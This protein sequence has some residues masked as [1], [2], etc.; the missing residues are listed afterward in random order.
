MV[1]NFDE[2]QPLD[3]PKSPLRTPCDLLGAG[4]LAPT[5]LTSIRQGLRSGSLRRLCKPDCQDRRRQQ[6]N[7][8]AGNANGPAEAIE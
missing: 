5:S 8:D 1:E 3:E 6:R 4:D 7:G 2:P